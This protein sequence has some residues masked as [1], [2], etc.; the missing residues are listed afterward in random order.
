LLLTLVA[1]GRIDFD[2][3]AT[4]NPDGGMLP[5]GRWASIAAGVNDTC[6]VTATGE[7]WCWGD[8]NTQALPAPRALSVDVFR[9]DA[10]TDYVAVAVSNGHGCALRADHSLWCFGSGLLGDGAMSASAPPEQ[11]GTANW[12]A[13]AVGTSHTCAIQDDGSLWCWGF[14]NVG[15]LGDGAITGQPVPEHIGVASW[16]S[17]FAVQSDTC[18]IQ[19]D[20]TGWCWGANIGGELGTG[21]RLERL[22]PAALPGTWATLAI[23]ET[24]GCGTTTA[25]T[26][27]CWGTQG[28]GALGTGDGIDH[29]APTAITVPPLDTIAVTETSTCG[30]AAGALW[31]WGDDTHGQ[32]GL[33]SDVDPQVPQ[34]IVAP[35]VTA[36]VSGA[37]H[38]C[39]LDDAHHMFC[40]G[41]DFLGQTG[42]TATVLRGPIRAD[43]AND[44][45][46]LALAG[47][48]CGLAGTEL[49][50]WGAGPVGDGTLRD[51]Q[52]PTTISGAFA[53]VATGGGVVAAALDGTM[54][55]WGPD[56]V[57]RTPVTTPTT[58]AT[59]VTELA[60]G[61]AHICWLVGTSLHCGG[62]NAAGQLGDG[63]TNDAADV[64]VA[65][66]WTGVAAA[67][68][69]TCGFQGT[70]LSCWGDNSSGQVIYAGGQAF[71]PAVMFGGVPVRSVAIGVASTCALEMSGQ[72]VCQGTNGDGQLGHS[73][74]N[75]APAQVGTRSDW[76]AIASG[77]R[78]MIA[79]AGD[80]TLWGWGDEFYGELG[81]YDPAQRNTVTPTQ[82]GTRTDWVDVAANDT[83]SCA[84]A[85]DHSRWCFGTSDVG[86]LGDRNSW[87]ETF[88]VVP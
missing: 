3:L 76:T 59:G 35:R 20:G 80:G 48:S 61:Y 54:L 78:H 41:G 72:I 81:F 79:V 82:V 50:C 23:S 9:V 1:C 56:L 18:G 62:S 70:A 29:L 26:V 65:G 8:N 57:T 71:A 30:T 16:T 84:I 42:K 32:L 10:S 74:A 2:P 22:S 12:R 88:Q 67:A 75:G 64:V 37:S 14:D 45:T 83:F 36:L 5:A 77:T 47:P 51:R 69:E 11:I 6:A 33:A 58:I 25:G 40:T 66:T 68:Q 86:A 27:S 4:A 46:S 52:D 63:T 43:T 13:V 24:H 55:R 17:V 49:R 44:W 28:S 15:Q 7:L 39:I 60:S 31:C 21:D 53:R 85:S 38:T 87:A 19:S 34:Q 73:G